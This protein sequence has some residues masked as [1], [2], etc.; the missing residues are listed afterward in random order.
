M[1]GSRLRPVSLRLHGPDCLFKCLLPSPASPQ[2]ANVGSSLHPLH[3]HGHPALPAESRLPA[4]TA[5]LQLSP[6]LPR[7]HPATRHL[8][9]GLR[10]RGDEESR[11]E[12]RF[13]P[14]IPPQS[15]RHPL[16]GA[17]IQRYIQPAAATG[18]VSPL[19][20]YRDPKINLPNQIRNW[21]PQMNR[22]RKSGRNTHRACAGQAAMRPGSLPRPAC[23]HPSAGAQGWTPKKNSQTAPGSLRAT[24][25]RGLQRS[26]PSSLEAGA[27]GTMLSAHPPIQ[28]PSHRP[29]LLNAHPTSRHH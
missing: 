27:A 9:A 11:G 7:R 24:E 21:G 8:G 25:W 18:H 19:L 16:P 14:F 13:F 15:G 22:A 23:P 1:L 3:L 17:K 28:P 26:G 10:M 5:P 6:Q 12:S 4:G 2:D 29:A 20:G